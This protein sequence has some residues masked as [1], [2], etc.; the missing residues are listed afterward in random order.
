MKHKHGSR[1]RRRALIATLA[2]MVPLTALGVAA[3]AQATPKG[4]F[5]I[6]ADCPLATFKA[7]GIPPGSAQCQFGETLSGEFAIGSTKVPIKNTITQQGG[8]IPNGTSEI[9]FFLIPGADGATLSKTEQNVPGGLLNL[10]NCEEIKG[11][12]LFEKLERATCKAIFE[13]KTTGVTAVT[14]T[15]ANTKNPAILNEL[16]LNTQKGVALQLPVRVHL[17]NPLLGESCYIGSEASPIELELTT[18]TTSPKS[19]NKPISGK[20]GTAETLEEKE[21]LMLRIKENSL[22]DNNFSVPVAEGCG[23]FFSFIIDPIV[24]GKLGLPSAAGN[25]TGILNGTLNVATAEAVEASEKF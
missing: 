5:A 23:G 4:I 18:G 14:E 6:F 12:G 24:D 7:L 16:N 20:R 2:L 1:L 21:Q 11:E 13:N 3:P 9:E 19:P 25:N 8:A 22:V 17:K 15:V 10:V